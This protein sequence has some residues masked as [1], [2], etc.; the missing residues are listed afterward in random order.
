MKTILN[1]DFMSFFELKNNLIIILGIPDL[2]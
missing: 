1:D 2:S